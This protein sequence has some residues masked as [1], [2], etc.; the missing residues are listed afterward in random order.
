M[1]LIVNFMD[2]NKK[3]SCCNSMQTCSFT[4]QY[5]DTYLYVAISANLRLYNS[6]PGCCRWYITFNGAE[7]SDPDRIEAVTYAGG[8][9]GYN[10]HRP[11]VFFGRLSRTQIDRGVQK[12]S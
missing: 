7:C 1:S 8:Y 12:A 10:L 11:R 2:P 6:N 5:S 4:K 9:S 3:F